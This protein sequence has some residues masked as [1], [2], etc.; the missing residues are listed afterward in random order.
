MTGHHGRPVLAWSS[1]RQTIAFGVVVVAAISAASVGR[2]QGC[3]ATFAWPPDPKTQPLGKI[4][5]ANRGSTFCNSGATATAFVA[6][7]RLTFS[8]GVCW[9]SNDGFNVGIGTLIAGKRK[10][11]DPPGFWLQDFKS[12]ATFGQHSVDLAKGAVTWRGGVKVNRTK[13]TFAGKA[14]VLVGGKLTSVSLT[15]SYTC[16]RILDAPDQ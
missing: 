6:G 7:K 1:A 2:A 12:A 3:T 8:G 4:Y 9:K 11:T 10:K 13:K 16:R 5:G 15:G 14:S